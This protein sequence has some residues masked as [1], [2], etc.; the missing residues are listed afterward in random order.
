MSLLKD[1]ELAR[2]P[3]RMNRSS[4]SMAFESRTRSSLPE[5]VRNSQRM[6]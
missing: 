1:T 3:I 2:A 6:P 4:S 5:A